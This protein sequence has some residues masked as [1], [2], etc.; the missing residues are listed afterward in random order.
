MTTTSK[1]VLQA[2]AVTMEVTGTE[3]SAAAAKVFAADLAPYPEAQILAALERVRKEVR[4]RMTVADVIS[5]IDDGRPTADE[6]WAMIPTTEA[7]SCVWTFEMATAFGLACKLMTT[8]DS[9]AARMAFRATYEREVKVAREHALPVRWFPS[10]GSDATLRAAVLEDAVA[11]GR[12]SAA[13]AAKLLPDLELSPAIAAL[14]AP[15]AAKLIV[16]P[17]NGR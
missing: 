17:R 12:M 4:G 13:H 8:R 2:I 9:T 3:L 5:R 14:V 7:E 10:L 6:A 15:V 1:A 16:E 11:K